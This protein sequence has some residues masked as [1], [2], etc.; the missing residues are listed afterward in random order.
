[1]GALR[2][3]AIPS[4]EQAVVRMSD[5]A[6]HHGGSL[7]TGQGRSGSGGVV[8][9]ECQ[10]L[11]RVLGRY[12]A[13]PRFAHLAHRYR[14]QAHNGPG[15]G[16]LLSADSAATMRSLRPRRPRGSAPAARTTV[17]SPLR[18]SA[19]PDWKLDYCNIQR[20]TPEEIAR[21]RVEFDKGKTQ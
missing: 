11:H 13:G 20:V 4:V 14:P 3:G 21:R 1:M 10:V 17:Q 12:G 19:N 5:R 6:H 15:S 9:R 7:S 8:Q 2:R 16:D 18:W